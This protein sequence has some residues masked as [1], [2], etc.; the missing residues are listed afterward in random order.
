MEKVRKDIKG[1]GEIIPKEKTKPR[2]ISKSF[3]E[4]LDSEHDNLIT[5][6]EGVSSYMYQ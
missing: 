3:T 2:E 6:S 1:Y 4:K 5:V